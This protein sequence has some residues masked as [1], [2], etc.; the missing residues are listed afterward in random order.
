[1]IVNDELD[2]LRKE[3]MVITVGRWSVLCCCPRVASRVEGKYK[4]TSNHK[5]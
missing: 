1:M 2:G 5:M 3:V 4:K